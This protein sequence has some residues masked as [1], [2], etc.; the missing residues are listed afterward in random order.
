M[1]LRS[2]KAMTKGLKI[3]CIGGGSGLSSLLKGLKYHTDNIMAIVTVGDDGGSSGRL[4]REL[5]VLPPGDIRNCL[6][7]LAHKE[8]SM[9]ALL[10]HR[11]MS[12]SL[13]GHSIGN[14]ILAALAEQYGDI[15]KG[16]EQLSK[17]FA[18]KGKV[19]P[20]TLEDM[21]LEATL[22]DG[23]FVCGETAIRNAPGRVKHLDISP[24]DCAPPPEVPKAIRE[25]DLVIL[26][27]GSLF[28]SIL[29]NLM[30]K[31]LREAIR[32]SAAPCVYICNIMTEKGETDGFTVSDHVRALIE[33]C[34]TG[35]VNAV[36]ASVENISPEVLAAYDREGAV[37][38]ELDADRVLSLGVSCFDSQFYSGGAVVR[39]DPA[40]LSQTVLAVARN[41]G[42]K[43]I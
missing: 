20:A 30:V 37:P 33:H 21:T 2:R 16:I 39:H 34:G 10:S 32:Q 6:V 1:K 3:A 27:P 41:L 5:G 31:E 17:I 15:R 36:L 25:A 29:P 24:R 38:V 7:A 14:L 40:L 12:G 9:E 11:F 26:G 4:R 13:E 19:C 18:L 43:I 28:T 42:V 8:E 23:S 22:E 35:L